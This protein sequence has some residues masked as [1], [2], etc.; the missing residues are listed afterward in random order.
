MR[1][2]L[3]KFYGTDG[4]HGYGYGQD[5]DQ[6]QLG[7]WY[8]ISSMG[9]FDVAGLCNINPKFSL[10]SPKFNRITI[11]LHPDYYKGREFVIEAPGNSDTNKYA[12]KYMLNGRVITDL[13]LSFSAVTS[14]GKLVVEM[15]DT[16]KNKY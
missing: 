16:P 13:N 12:Q 3:D 4:I 7:A 14:G 10:G 8:V 6:G 1:T 9:I 11:Q 15:G 2:I 5:E